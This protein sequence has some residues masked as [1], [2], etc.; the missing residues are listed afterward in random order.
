MDD[1]A[2]ERSPAYYEQANVHQELAQAYSTQVRIYH[3]TEFRSQFKRVCVDTAVW[4][5]WDIGD[6]VN[7]SSSSL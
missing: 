6:F 7:D 1:T 4:T 3:D 2:V 5:C